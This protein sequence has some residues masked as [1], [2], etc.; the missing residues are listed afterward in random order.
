MAANYSDDDD[1]AQMQSLASIMQGL[2]IDGIG[3]KTVRYLS[4][5]EQQNIL[6]NHI[7]LPHFLPASTGPRFHNTELKLFDEMFKTVMDLSHSIP[8]KT[9]ALFKSMHTIHHKLT[10]K[11]V[12][13]EINALQ[14]G[15]TFAM[16]VRRQNC[17]FMVHVPPDERIVHGKPQNA[18]VATFTGR[19]HPNEV[20]NCDSDIEVNFHPL[21]AFDL[22]R[23]LIDLYFIL[24]ISSSHTHS[25]RSK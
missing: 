16:F 4:P 15:D 14:P 23:K 3:S 5:L 13:K 2:E 21:K 11:V 6:L 8:A 19:L 20:Y 24:L 22:N 1:D 9:V 7:I 12:S 18:I 25:K 17:T 10:P